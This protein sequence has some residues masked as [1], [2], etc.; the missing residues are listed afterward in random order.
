[1]DETDADALAAYRAVNVEGNADWQSRRRLVFLNSVGVNGGYTG[2]LPRPLDGGSPRFVR[3][4]IVK[5]VEDYAVSKWE[6]EQA[7]WEVSAK[8]GLEDVVVRLPLVYGPGVPLPLGAVR[9]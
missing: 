5:P 8:T 2:G 9:N 7:L 3:Y 1:M 6:A 4:D